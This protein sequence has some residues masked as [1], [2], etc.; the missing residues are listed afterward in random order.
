MSL[1][2]L[3]ANAVPEGSF[4]E[5]NTLHSEFEELRR[6]SRYEHPLEGEF[7]RAP[8]VLDNMVRHLSF[9]NGYRPT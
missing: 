4:E 9:Q 3:D 1:Q 2:V 8:L 7:P 6:F 5:G